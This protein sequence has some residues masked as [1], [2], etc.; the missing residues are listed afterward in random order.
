MTTRAILAAMLLVAC[1]ESYPPQHLSSWGLFADGSMQTP[2]EDVV[3]YDIISPLFS[4]Y[5]A[6]HR[7]IRLPDGAQITYTDAGDWEFPTGTVLV[8]TFAFSDD[9]RDPSAGERIVE[10]RLLV[11][12]EDGEWHPYVYVWDDAER[13]AVYI[14]QGAT[15]DVSWIHSDGSEREL[16]YHVPNIVECA[17]CH[18]GA[19][20]VSPIGP[21]TEQIDRDDQIEGLISRGWFANAVPPYAERDRL[22]APTGTGDLDARARAYLDAN[23]SHCHREGGAAGQSG[24]WLGAE[25]TDPIVLGLCKRPLAAGRATGGFSYDIVPGNPDESIMI[26]RMESS[27][28]GVKMPE[29]GTLTHVEGVALIREWIAAMPAD[30][31]E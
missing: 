5:A 16:G 8:K 12:E 29:F 23:C 6:K 3:P 22:E 26:Y 31:C 17:N 18:G 13:D 14:P 19:D 27:E 28:P 10:T 20:D 11:L 2:A 1:E 30:T 24:L 7:F 4:D 9:L 15:V 25:I 21:R